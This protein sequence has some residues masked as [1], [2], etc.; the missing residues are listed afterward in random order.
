MTP[1]TIAIWLKPSHLLIETWWQYWPVYIVAAFCEAWL[2][3]RAIKSPGAGRR[4]PIFLESIPILIWACWANQTLFSSFFSLDKVY[5]SWLKLASLMLI[6]C[7]GSF[8][9]VA[10][11]LAPGF[12]LRRR[13]HPCEQDRG[14]MARVFAFLSVAFDWLASWTMIVST[15]ALR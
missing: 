1:P 6:P 14:T 8:V 10:V 2:V 3:L 15:Y 11:L 12:F 4:R 7:A 13:L 9:V 5:E